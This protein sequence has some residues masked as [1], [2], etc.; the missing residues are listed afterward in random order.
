MKVQEIMT[1][2]VKACSPDTNL[3]TAAVLMYENDCGILPV[4][5]NGGSTVG[6][7]TDRDIAIAVGTR[8]RTPQELRVDEVSQGRVIACTQDDDVHTALETMRKDKVRRL[9]VLNKDG[10]L[11]G[12]LSINDLVVHA[13]KGNKELDYDD[14][15][16]TFKAI[17][18]HP[19]LMGHSTATQA[20]G[21]D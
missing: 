5:L 14:V 15:V 12:I 17:C 21:S 3:A 10:E 20:G 6:V 16:S 11:K 2:N 1:Q 4:V 8:G 13:L 19:R 9:P 7:I 18:A